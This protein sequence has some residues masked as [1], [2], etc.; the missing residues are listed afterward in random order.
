M[1]FK[2]DI[3]RVKWI[4][5]SYGLPECVYKINVPGVTTIINE[6]IPDPSWDEF[7]LS[8]GKEKADIILKGAGNRGSS[9]HTYIE[10]FLENYSK[11]NDVSEALRYTQ[12]ESLK[13]LR[14]QDIPDN[15]IEEGRNLFYKFYYSD[16]PQVFAKLIA[17]ELGLYSPSLYYR[18]K[19]DILYN[20]SLYGISITD[21]KS[22]NGKVKK[23]SAKEIKF[24][25][26]L[27]AYVYAL[28]EMYR[29]K[30]TEVKY[31]SILCIDKQTDILQEIE[32]TGKELIEYK[33]KFVELAKE[34]HRIHH[35]EY[36]IN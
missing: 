31:A 27:G 19:L 14:E 9:M 6:L 4:K 15:K 8:V 28:E 22:S 34:W 16:K 3:N 12:E 7:V 23:G 25:L 13:L 10:K 1:G 24:K 5:G 26:Q 11:S 36:L 20:S 35:Q 30:K 29:E 17:M 32:L 21:F 18:G 33:Q 2:F